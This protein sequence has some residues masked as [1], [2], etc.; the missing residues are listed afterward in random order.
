MTPWSLL[1][2]GFAILGLI[3]LAVLYRLGAG[4]V[5]DAACGV[6]AA[7]AIGLLAMFGR[8]QRDGGEQP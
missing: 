5:A 4:W 6:L 8:A 2:A 7:T 1:A 3:F